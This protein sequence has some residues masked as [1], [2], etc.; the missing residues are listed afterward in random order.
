[1]DKL[2][3]YG[4]AF[5]P[6][7]KAHIELAK[8]AIKK[9]KLNKV[10]FI[11]VNDFYKKE[12]LAPEIHRLN[13]LKLLCENE[14]KLEVSDIEMKTEKCFKAI[15]IFNLINNEYK[16][17]TNY[18]IMGIDNLANIFRWKDYEKLISDFKY[19]IFDR[20]NIKSKSVIEDNDLLRKYK[21]NFK[22]VENEEHN[23]YSST[24]TRKMI[25]NGQKPVNIDKRIYEYINQNGL[26]KNAKIT[27]M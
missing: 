7:T 11:P 12:G 3:F 4:G 8:K 14:E 25:E 17:S 13:M 18:F 20:G 15:D 5:N 21:K 10:I 19:I 23:N 22:I 9:F 2:G 1:M 6:P 27:N 26:Y 16:N 24:Y